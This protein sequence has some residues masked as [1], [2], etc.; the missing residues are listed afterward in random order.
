MT[1]KEKIA[2]LAAAVAGLL[3]EVGDSDVRLGDDGYLLGFHDESIVV[4]G[5]PVATG[6]TK[7]KIVY[8]GAEEER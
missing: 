6:V 4:D 8:F 1:D 2:I 5:E 3:H 7:A